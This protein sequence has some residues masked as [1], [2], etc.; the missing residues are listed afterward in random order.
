MPNAEDQ[1]QPEGEERPEISDAVDSTSNDEEP[2]PTETSSKPSSVPIARFL[3]ERDKTKQQK[4]ELDELKREKDALKQEKDLA[5]MAISAPPEAELEDL[6]P[7]NPD[8]YFGD[9][10][11]YVAAFK[12][13]NEANTARLTQNMQSIVQESISAQEQAK[14]EQQQQAELTAK[15]QEKL[16]AHYARADSLKAEDYVES[17]DR[18]KQWLGSGLFDAV[19][20]A[21]DNSEQI[22]YALGNNKEKTLELLN[23]VKDDPLYGYKELIAY[24]GQLDPIKPSG[25][26]LPEPDSPIEGGAGGVVGGA[27]AAIE[28]SRD[29]YLTGKI[30]LQQHMQNRTQIRDKYAA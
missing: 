10:D 27:D 6:I 16:S 9:H 20:S 7:P 1:V 4:K 29:K 26:L 2:Q 11:G 17:E 22:V 13:Y 30:S 14:L 28:K 23:A 8:D 5:L 3:E 25:E 15:H 19:V 18:A 12:K 24:A 21:F